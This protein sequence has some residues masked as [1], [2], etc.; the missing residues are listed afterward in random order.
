M[1]S[2]DEADYRAF[3]SARAHPLR[4]TAYLLCGDWQHAEDLVQSAFTSLYVNWHRVRDRASLDGYV[5]T[6]LVRCLIDESRRPWRRETA[7]ERIPDTAAP[8][9]LGFEDRHLVRS[10]MRALP[11][12]QRAVVVL[13]FFDDFDVAQTAEVLGCSQGTVKS[14]TA[15]A[16]TALRTELGQHW[17]VPADCDGGLR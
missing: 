2:D 15:R 10:A 9:P 17:P 7:S 5:R 11:V 8:E 12:R 13:R 14:Y 4:R 6:T 1:R 3:V 16:L